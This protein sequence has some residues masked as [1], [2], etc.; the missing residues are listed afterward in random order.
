VEIQSELPEQQPPVA[1]DR[2]PRWIFFGE[3]G[4]RAGWSALLFLVILAALGTGTIFIAH[5]FVHSRLNPNAP[6]GPR[7]ALIQEVLQLVLVLIATAIMAIFEKRRVGAYGYSG[8][9]KL[10]RFCWGTVWGFI[11]ISVLVGV[12]W[13]LRLLGFDG[14][15]L[16]GTRACEYA[17]AWAV[18]FL[19]VGL[20]EESLLRGYL[21][22]T[23]ARGIGFWWAALLLSVTFGA[24]HGHNVG[25]SPIGL[26]S[27]GAVGLVF[28]LSLWYT[29][30]L[31]WA[32]G[33]HA[34]WDWGQS[35]FYGTSDSGMVAR[36]HLL[37]EHPAGP[38][39]WSGGATGP[40]GSLLILP[41]LAIMALA[42]WLWWGRKAHRERAYH[43]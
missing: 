40:E 42:M 32:I 25:E 15:L 16:H 28:C 3:N 18:V 13:K 11:A 7:L 22:Y 38:L 12:L 1:P 21:Q 35:Y 29:G 14:S 24:L 8:N 30:S 33:F 4:L 19:C 23:L 37:S 36:G 5:L 2:G 9:A 10:V 27:A 39:L 17:L 31:W 43:A 34:A 26:F 20:A 6:L 41:L